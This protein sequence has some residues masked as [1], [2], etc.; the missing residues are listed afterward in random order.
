MTLRNQDLLRSYATDIIPPDDTLSEAMYNNVKLTHYFGNLPA[1]EE[2][3]DTPD[4]QPST[5]LTT[6]K[7][8][9]SST[10]SDWQLVRTLAGAHKG[11]IRCIAIDEITN[12]WYVT[13]LADSTIKIWDF[14]N[15]SLKAILT[16]HVLGVRSLCI[17]KRFPYLFSGGEDKSLR[18]WDLERTNSPAG[19]Q[20]RSYHGHLGGV[21]SIA[22]HPELDL[23]FS[24]GKDCVVRVWDIRSR[25]E[26]MTLLGH[27]NDITSIQTDYSDPQVITSSMDGTIRLWDLRNQ[28]TELLITN[29]S[30]SI[31]SMRSHPKE[32]TFVSGDGNGE[33][34]QWLLPKG[35]LLNEFQ[36]SPKETNQRDN[37]RIINTLSINP[38][39]NTLFSGYDD[40]RLEFYDYMNGTS[41]QS[42][43]SPSLSGSQDD[44]AIYASTFDMSGLRLLTCH[45]DKSIRIWGKSSY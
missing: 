7:P 38:V 23:L 22:L 33:I 43:Y 36:S 12:K 15:N 29:H 13:G 30:K 3:P 5:Q 14:E 17:S 31:R 19:C 6:R 11:W 42:G 8:T 25:A 9:V 20:I 16:G 37:S 4:D 24:G 41:Q 34:K 40:G 44:A 10:H 18:C 2:L 28:K 39:S 26:A 21:Y 1:Q 27:Q 32:T 45:G 35:E